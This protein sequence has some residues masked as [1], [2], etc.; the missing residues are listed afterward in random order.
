M[1][2]ILNRPPN[3]PEKTS[4]GKDQ[5]QLRRISKKPPQDKLRR[6]EF[7]KSEVYFL[8]ASQFPLIGFPR[9]S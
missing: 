9:L 4:F 7:Q 2:L 3:M 6:L 1:D 8:C 5:T